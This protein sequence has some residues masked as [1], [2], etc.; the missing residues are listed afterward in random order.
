[1]TRKIKDVSLIF[2]LMIFAGIGLLYASLNHGNIQGRITDQQGATVPGAKIIVK[3][4]DTG[5]SAVLTTNS[6][7]LYLAPELVPGRYS[8]HIEAPGFASVDITNVVV[9]ANTTTEED[10]QLK[11][12]GTTQVVQVKA[13]P[14]LVQSAPSNFSTNLAGRY[15][16]NVPLP[17]RDIQ[18]LVQLIPGVTQSTG[19]SGAVFGFDSQFGGFP[20]PQ[21]L[22]GSGISANGSQGGANAWYLDGSLNAALGAENVVVNPSP[23]A[24]AEFNVVD[25]GLAAEYGRTSG[26]A[27]NVVLKSGTNQVHGDI[28]EFNR[29][30]FFN[31]TNP[32]DRRNSQG[33]EF[34]EPA[35]N[36]ND[37]GG[38]IG[39]PIDLPHIYNG[40][41]KTFFFASWDISMLHEN[42]PMLLTVPLPGE[43]NGD[44]TQDPALAPVCGVN[45]AT[46]CLYNPY[47][48]VGPDANGL[49][50]RTPF[51]TPVI[52]QSMI[53]P[54]AA[55]YV[56]SYPAPNF[57]D[58]LQQG[59]GGCGVTCN[60]FIGPVGSSQTTHNISIKVDQN[61]SSK[62]KLFVEWLF[63]PSYYTNYR[64]PWNG[65]T[66]PTST[67]IAGAQPYRTINQIATVGFTSALTPTLLNEARMEFSR[68]NQIA[69]PNPDS[70]ADTAA[71]ENEVKNLN[72]ILFPPTQVVPTIGIGGLASVGQQQWQNG[73]QGVQAYTF[74]DNVTKILGKHTLKT[75]MMFRRDNN[76]NI[77]G[78]GYGLNFGGGLTADPVTG[79]GG[80]GL[81]QFLMGAVDQGSG[82]G[83]YHAPWQTNNYWGAYIQDDY[84]VKPNLTLNLGL[85]YDYFGWFY[86]R[87]NDLANFDFNAQNPDVPFKGAIVYFGTPQHPSR[88]V[89]PA[90]GPDFGP[91]FGF[92]WSPFKSRKTVIRGGYGVIFS[93]GISSAFGDQNG[94]ISAPAFANFVAYNGDF[95]GQRPAF[96]LSKGAP[97]LN[98][99]PADFAKRDNDQFLTT[100]FNLF[101]K[102][103][104]DPYVEQ[105]SFNIQQQLSTNMSL[106]VG[107]VGTHGMH[108][109]GDEFRGY[110]YIPTAVRQK[111]RTNITNPVPVD[112][113]LGP[114]YGCPADPTIP[115]KVDCPGDIAFRPY[116][117]YGG[118]FANVSPNGFNDY[119]SFQLRWEERYSHGLN[120]IVA[121]TIQKNI[122]AAN[123]GSIIGNT[124]TPT[125]LARA[126]G[127]SS[128]IPGAISGGSGNFA[129][130]AAAENPD[131]L[132]CYIGLA[133]D[134]T[135]QILNFA[136]TYQ[137]PAGPGRRYFTRGPLSKIL[138]G[139]LLTQNWN[140]QSGVPI[141]IT[142]PCNGIGSCRP[143][144]IGNPA[145]G[146]SGNL[147]QR[148]N[149]WWNPN[150]FEAN[151]GNDP[152]VIQEVS[153]GLNPDGTPFNYN[154][155]DSW[156]QYGNE[157]TNC[158]HCRAPG[159]WNL[160]AAL[161]K[162]FHFSESKYFEIQW[163][164]F[165]ALNHQ[166][167][168]L[169]NN[170]W[171]LPP[172][173][174]GEIDAVHQFGC[175]F[176]KITNVQ[177]DPRNMEF[178]LKFYW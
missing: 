72:F 95:T 172:G 174:N 1:M 30:S 147:A 67:G 45:G 6:D 53:D 15:I 134:D 87:Y 107:Y 12:G 90:N 127:R 46:N 153:T 158:P 173:P 166:N 28:Y 47:S 80:A 20:D 86:E 40:K 21:H 176:G 37:F 71:V 130:S 162:D 123:Y 23:D 133:P 29:N 31:A 81:A 109:Y 65:A 151:F 5:V 35:E 128:L 97:P 43:V 117:Q 141:M 79:Q 99:P 4:V 171:C 155:L 177:T 22:V 78:W 168:G 48:T 68:Q 69:S 139:W 145:A 93:N 102:A 100:G 163:Q 159:F 135:P 96:Q 10:T 120:F 136:V 18:T 64:Y 106:S 60:N 63:N 49:F 74:T 167:L 27:V 59:P 110:N 2:V 113:S 42:K 114:L 178:G 108:L 124:A 34:L 32:F 169:P 175:Q 17:G 14:S 11:V 115:N 154:S 140:F 56:K 73:I 111:L 41:D 122:E 88:T 125:T 16:Q 58:P 126:V 92:A 83:T 132:N 152:T 156:W 19:P 104:E 44:F 101:L 62:H 91:R 13:A 82:T 66:A 105:W 149:Q 131:C 164:V 85:R 70:V 94:A 98:L 116:P 170:H 144:I 165:N 51:T 50:H 150:A 84:Y 75:G 55:F 142:G 26:A 52:P 54:V 161:T 103:P 25:N 7:G 146:R 33:V 138:G 9:S 76:W 160:D 89:F 137:L 129:G 148:E 3:N 143:N 39:G 77:A 157:G 57:I 36:Y 38:T 118:F 121:Y 112:A 119:N 61:V 8:I 24:V